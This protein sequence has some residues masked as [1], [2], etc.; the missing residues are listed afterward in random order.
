MNNFV[1]PNL[2]VS[3]LAGLNFF[4]KN[5][6]TLLNLKKL[7]PGFV[8]GSVNA[9]HTGKMIFDN[10]PVFFA[11]EGN[12][13]TQLK[14]YKSLIKSG[15]IKEAVII[16]AS[17]EKDSTWEIKAAQAAGL[18]TTLLTCQAE[19]TGVRLADQFFTFQKSPEPYS[20]NFSTYLGM[21]LG[22]TAEKPEK[23]KKFLKNIKLPKNF[24]NYRSF[25]FILPDR[26]RP[27]V[28]MINVK[29]DELFGPH[30]SLRA[31]SEGNARHAKFICRSEKELVISFGANRFFGNQKHRWNLK[32]PKD[33]NYGLALSIS[34]YI[35]GFIQT[36]RPAYFKKGLLE[37]CQKTG[38]RPYGQK[39][40]FSIIVK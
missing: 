31:Y 25:T 8:V 5:K 34:Y 23:I 4:I 35:I 15:T 26:F 19:S 7:A 1:L 10:Q 38:P 14:I 13:L 27:I 20:Y 12:F 16:S 11:D 6:P 33:A 29:D 36:S 2:N 17:G 24:K 32:L 3:V 37:Y 21:I 22:V 9:Y 30:S 40:P 28:D 39:K 18:K